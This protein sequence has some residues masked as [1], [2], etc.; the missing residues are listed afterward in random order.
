MLK[1]NYRRSLHRLVQDLKLHKQDME[2]RRK[3]TKKQ[4]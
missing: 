3:S 4:K 1:Q 2:T